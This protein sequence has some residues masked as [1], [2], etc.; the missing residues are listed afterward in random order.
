MHHPNYLAFHRRQNCLSEQELAALL[1][2]SSRSSVSRCE[3]GERIPTLRFA[4][5][6]EVVFGVPAARLFPGLFQK[7]EE[8]V[9]TNGAKLDK[10]LRGLT[11][12]GAARKRRLLQ[13]I[14]GRV[15]N[16]PMA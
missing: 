16:A 11:G 14:V 8:T 10:S 3:S 6:C 1:G 4:M 9:L 12:E 5:A 2:Y 13:G 15:G 7:V